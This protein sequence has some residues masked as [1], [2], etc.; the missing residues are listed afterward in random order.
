MSL[1]LILFEIMGIEIMEA[2]L[3][4]KLLNMG[5][6]SLIP[7]REFPPCMGSTVVIMTLSAMLVDDDDF[8]VE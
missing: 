5:H 2:K 8:L 3:I 4:H 7:S 6:M 1:P